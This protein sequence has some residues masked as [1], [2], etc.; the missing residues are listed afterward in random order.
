MLGAIVPQGLFLWCLFSYETALSQKT[1]DPAFF[2]PNFPQGAGCQGTVWEQQHPPR[3]M[4]RVKGGLQ[5]FGSDPKC[6]HPC[7][8]LGCSWRAKTK[9]AC[10]KLPEVSS[11]TFFI[12]FENTER[13]QN[14][15]K[16]NPAQWLGSLHRASMGTLSIFFCFR[17]IG[18]KLLG[19]GQLLRLGEFY[20]GG[21]TESTGSR[22]S[23][24]RKLLKSLL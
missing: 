6:P 17:R 12:F 19:Y 16:C 5:G 14:T 20:S 22:G 4:L 21:E 24:N 3:G 10:A 18:Y 7:Q 11:S 8:G 9:S 13:A 2:W 1:T 15:Y 23:W